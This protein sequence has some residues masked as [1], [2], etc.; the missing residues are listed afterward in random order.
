MGTP[1]A[2]DLARPGARLDR[3]L[4]PRVFLPLLLVLAL[5][6]SLWF[7]RLGLPGAD[8]GTV[9]TNAVKL[10]RGS[11]YYRDIDAYPFPLAT[12]LVAAAM[13]LFEEHL[14][15]S[16]GLA[17]LFY[18]GLVASL[19][20]CALEI[21]G[22]RR[23][24]LFGLALLP[25][26]YLAWPSFS[27]YVYWDVAF[28]FA[29]ASIALLL[30][31]RF[32]GG[33]LRLAAAGLLAGL[34][35]L[36]KQTVGIYLAG[37][38][39]AALLLARPLFGV[40]RRG[41]RA[42]ARDVVAFVAGVGAPLAAAAAYFAAQGVLGRMLESGLVRP[43]TGYLPTSGIPFSVPLAWWDV[44]SMRGQ[45]GAAYFC[46]RLW[47]LLQLGPLADGPL[48]GLLWSAGE[49]FSR[50]L[51]SSVP[52]SFLAAAALWIR[53]SRHGD[54]AR[55]RG[56]LLLALLAGAVFCSAFPRMDYPHVI[57]VYP[58]VGLLAYALWARFAERL[59]A[60]ALAAETAALALVAAVCVLLAGVDARWNDRRIRV[61]R[62]DV[63]VSDRDAWMES[64]VRF[65]E[66]ETAPSETIFVYGQQADLYFLT[67]RSFSWPFAQLYPG[68]TGDAD[69]SALLE[70]VK[71]EPPKLVIRGL[72]DWPGLPLL[73]SYV[74]RLDRWVSY[75]CARVP[76]VFE[77]FPPPAGAA[78]EWWVL[79]VLRPCQPGARCDRF[80]DFMGTQS[81]PSDG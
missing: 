51:Y 33:T 21:L 61:A 31:D 62:A 22:V 73:G 57:A 71:R 77:R 50:A 46:H 78:P 7:A 15:V 42:P 39:G 28:A 37:A 6:V 14:T 47:R 24:A 59:G 1:R 38:A 65:V 43:L 76:D 19:Y 74:P 52:L 67:G 40:G 44:G 56:L 4:R 26:K 41:G 55:D 75:R 35:L 70:R 9:L 36:A 58:L 5:G 80:A 2:P 18:L 81:M 10:L 11:V 66:A 64:L 13:G 49:I 30:G 48:E 34:A 72:M 69:G 32:R 25:L 23:A 53:A 3:L 60:R 79:S 54:F 68:Q 16:R 12:Y 27:V 63:W 17:S 29:C 8:E 45:E 20:A